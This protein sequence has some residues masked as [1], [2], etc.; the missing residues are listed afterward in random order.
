[1]S[2]SNRGFGVIGLTLQDNH[3]TMYR[4]QRTFKQQPNVQING[5]VNLPL[6]EDFVPG[7]TQAAGSAI[8]KINS[9]VDC[10]T[11]RQVL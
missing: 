7:L 5:V 11:L 3:D 4:F 1:M 8:V 2:L 9:S 10:V 6:F